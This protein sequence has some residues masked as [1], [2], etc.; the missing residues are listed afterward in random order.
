MVKIGLQVQ[1]QFLN[2]DRIN[3]GENFFLKLTCT[4]CNEID[5]T[6]HDVSL[7]VSSINHK[8]SVYI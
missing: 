5:S 2:V 6:F 1:L 3:F 7:S 8:S 4:N